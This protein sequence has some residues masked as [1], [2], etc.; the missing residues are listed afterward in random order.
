MRKFS[1]DSVKVRILLA[2]CISAVFSCAYSQ[3]TIPMP[4]LETSVNGK[5]ELMQL[6]AL[7]INVC[8]VGN[9]ATTTLDMTF[10][11]HSNRVLEGELEFPLG[12]GQTISRYAL[13]FNGKL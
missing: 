5:K 6:S 9:L 4:K 13:D 7:N 3:V 1:I 12:E 2:F 11:N 10:M 8:I